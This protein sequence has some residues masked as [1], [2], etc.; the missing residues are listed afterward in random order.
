MQVIHLNLAKS[1]MDKGFGMEK[2]CH[3]ITDEMAKFYSKECQ[4]AEKDGRACSH[5]LPVN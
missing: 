2:C 4:L 1:E 5:I 3:R